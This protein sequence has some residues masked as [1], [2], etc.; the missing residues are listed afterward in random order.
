MKSRNQTGLENEVN[1]MK[2]FVSLFFGVLIVIG[3]LGC[4]NQAKDVEIQ[5]GKI[6]FDDVFIEEF[7]RAINE[8]WAA[9]D[10]LDEYENE[11]VYNEKMLRF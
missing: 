2:K 8:R 5:E 7:S 9:Q 4:S 1:R 3:L 11:A 10:K 6:N